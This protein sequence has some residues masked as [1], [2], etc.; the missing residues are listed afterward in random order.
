MTL[1]VTLPLPPS[2][3]HSHYSARGRRFPTKAAKDWTADARERLAEA[4][5]LQRWPFCTGEKV[6]VE[7][8]TYFPD[9]RKRD[10]SNLMKLPLDALE[11]I[12]VDNDRWC[13]PRAVDFFVDKHRPRL[14][15]EIR[16]A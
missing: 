2:Q 4:V 14:E 8:T 12:V 9:K 1:S 13:L 15:L 16:R 10:C 7:Y 6:I 5:H 3:N 11:G